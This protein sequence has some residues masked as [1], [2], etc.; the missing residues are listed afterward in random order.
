MPGMR[1]LVNRGQQA[2]L[3]RT[4]GCALP[5]ALP[6]Q[7][8]CAIGQRR[9]SRP[10]QQGVGVAGA[11]IDSGDKRHWRMRV[12]VMVGESRARTTIKPDRSGEG[13]SAE[14]VSEVRC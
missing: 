1:H 4:E 11:C 5:R 3:G 7:A 2:E 13:Q 9:E 12:P 6:V 10:A 14:R 8:A